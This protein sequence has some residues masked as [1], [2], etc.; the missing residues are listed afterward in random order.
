MIL[1]LEKLNGVASV[2]DTGWMLSKPLDPLPDGNKTELNIARDDDPD[3]RV[4]GI[5]RR[6]MIANDFSLTPVAR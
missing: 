3:A 1:I 2:R 5:W 4:W 6:T